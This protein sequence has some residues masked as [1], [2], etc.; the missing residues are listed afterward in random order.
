MER[1]DFF[2]YAVIHK[3]GGVYADID[4]G[5]LRP[6][7]DW[8]VGGAGFVVGQEVCLAHTS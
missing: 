2:R 8:D 7:A 3:F 5:I 4:V 6:V 1:A